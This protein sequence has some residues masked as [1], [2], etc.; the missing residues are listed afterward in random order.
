MA[1]SPD[2]GPEMR[3]GAANLRIVASDY[4]ILNP[5]VSD[6][7]ILVVMNK[8]SMLRFVGSEGYVR[9]RKEDMANGYRASDQQLKIGGM[10]LYNSSFV[11]DDEVPAR[12]DLT[13]YP[14]PA[15]PVYRYRATIAGLLLV[16]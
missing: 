4:P 9:Q 8:P 10:L 16:A 11:K 6:P 5:V 14:V 2:Y 3:G 13:I 15:P 1:F 7:D 12:P